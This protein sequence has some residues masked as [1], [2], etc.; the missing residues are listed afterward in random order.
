MK[1]LRTWGKNRV[2]LIM[3]KF[4][5]TVFQ[6]NIGPLWFELSVTCS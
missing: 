4:C 6:S 2:K 5:T 3:G 1:H